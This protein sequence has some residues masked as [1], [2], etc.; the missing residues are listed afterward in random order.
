MSE[1]TIA[2]ALV[3]S[4]KRHRRKAA[5]FYPTPADV[6][7]ALMEFLNLDRGSTVW[8][9]ASGDGSMARVIARYCDEV[10]ASDLRDEPGVY[11]QR[12][13]DFLRSEPPCGVRPDWIITNPPFSVAEAFIEKALELAPNVAMLLSN[14]YW[15][16]ASR[17]PLFDKRRPQWVLPLLWRPAFLERERGRSPMM[18]VMWVV[19]GDEHGDARYRLLP[20]PTS[21]FALQDDDDDLLIDLFQD[22]ELLI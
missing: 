17:K 22:E 13:R 18:N 4:Q 16:A 6:T 3:K 12:N 14:Q 1:H 21:Q 9:P 19:W 15:H 2:S 5:D 7:Q 10:F 8:E 20:K 11:G